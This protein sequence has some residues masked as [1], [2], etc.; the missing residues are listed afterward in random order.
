MS[1]RLTDIKRT[2]RSR[3]DGERYLHPKLLQPTEMEGRMDLA[4]SYFH[5]RLGRARRDFDAEMLV[6]FFGDPKLA[7]GIVSC[8][9][10]TYRWRL[11]AF[12]DVLDGGELQRLGLHGIR[13]PSDLRLYLFDLVNRA[14]H[15]F[16][17]GD[18]KSELQ[19]QSGRL[20]L[21]PARLERLFSLDSEDNA[22]LVRAGDA[23][24]ARDVISQY[25]FQ[26]VH[27][28]IRNCEYL[29]FADLQVPARAALVAACRE[30]GV[31]LSEQGTA[32]RV[33]NRA[34]AF[35][36]YARW[37]QR[38]ARALYTTASVVPSLLQTGRARLQTRGRHAWYVFDRHTL[39]SLTGAIGA[40]WCADPLPE[41]ADRWQHRRPAG[42]TMG[43]HLTNLA[44]PFVCPAGLIVPSSRIMRGELEVLLWPLDT[45]TDGLAVTALHGAGRPV[46]AVRRSGAA[47][48]APEPVACVESR[49]RQRRVG[50]RAYCPLGHSAGRCERTGAG[51]AARRSSVARL[52]SRD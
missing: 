25:N 34:D 9:G 30:H 23:P 41:I 52:H 31:A 3:G 21:A 36:S 5:T 51:G 27:A 42:G 29:E 1:F 13:C 46:L 18:R 39:T 28:I 12:S 35:G 43:W 22:V 10:R 47:V 15:G 20:G 17:A 4:L 38:L 33:H 45:E 8:L 14:G 16:L 26:V 24:A 6:R 37:G 7:R 32:L 50:R 2:M 40:I 44:E 11:Q 48:V 19:V 49:D